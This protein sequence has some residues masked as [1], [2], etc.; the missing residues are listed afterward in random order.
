ME[1]LTQTLSGERNPVLEAVCLS[2]LMAEVCTCNS[3]QQR[4]FGL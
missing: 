2:F 1:R 3:L 4:D